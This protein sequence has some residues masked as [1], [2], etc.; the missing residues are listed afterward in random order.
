MVSDTV[1]PLKILRHI[2]CYLTMPVP[3][4]AHRNLRE[5]FDNG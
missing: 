4:I 1:Y 3:V 2:F 5:A